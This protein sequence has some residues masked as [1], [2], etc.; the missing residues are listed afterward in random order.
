[1]A[2]DSFDPDPFFT[3]LDTVESSKIDSDQFNLER[4]NA[5]QYGE[6]QAFLLSQ[7]LYHQQ[8]HDLIKQRKYWS[9]LTLGVLVVTAFVYIVV[10]LGVCWGC[11]SIDSNILTLLLTGIPVEILGLAFIIVKFLFH[12]SSLM[13]NPNKK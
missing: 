13:E 2:D 9:L 3:A 11:I 1:M 8:H 5:Q 7:G 4:Q 12:E 6:M 10:I